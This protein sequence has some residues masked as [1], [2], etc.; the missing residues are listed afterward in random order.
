MDEVLAVLVAVSIFLMMWL[1][2]LA[3]AVIVIGQRVT[4][5][6]RVHPDVPTPAPLAW[7]WAPTEP[8]RLH[9]R[10]QLVAAGVRPPGPVPPPP[11]FEPD[12]LHLDDI[13]RQVEYQAL[14]LDTDVTRASRLPRPERRRELRGLRHQVSA[15]ERVARR[16][17][18]HQRLPG[19]P[20]SGWASPE[21]AAAALERLD[22]RL[23]QLEAAHAELRAVEQQ[24]LEPSRWLERFGELQRPPD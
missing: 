3:G 23:D 4:R 6:N 17:H 22:G 5:A 15:T 13:A 18:Q 19:A 7:R 10:L 20:A 14:A 24:I 8:A 11:V 21:A 16:V 9:R 2:V 1:A 12:P